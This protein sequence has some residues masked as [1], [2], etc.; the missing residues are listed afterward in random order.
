MFLRMNW[1]VD[2]LLLLAATPVFA[3]DIPDI[4]VKAYCVELA[5]GSAARFNGCIKDEQ[6]A[7]NKLKSTWAKTSDR[8]QAYCANAWRNY[9]MIAYCIDDEMKAVKEGPSEFKK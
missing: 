8:S 3:A 5:S 7:Y 6:K 1:P 2:I 9:G 4:D